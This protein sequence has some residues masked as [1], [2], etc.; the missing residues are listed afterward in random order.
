LDRDARDQPGA[1]S[2]ATVAFGYSWS[3]IV[4]AALWA[5]F[6]GAVLLSLM[7]PLKLWARTQRTAGL[8]GNLLL[9][10]MIMV[11][12]SLIPFEAM[13]GW[14]ADIGRFTPNGSSMEVLKSHPVREQRAARVRESVRRCSPVLGAFTFTLSTWRMRAFARE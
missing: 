6:A 3:R 12:G 9:F 4:P 7:C 11:G 8:I 1:L 14:L 13:P 5:S 2:L 10:P